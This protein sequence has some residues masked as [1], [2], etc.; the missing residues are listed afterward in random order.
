MD[1]LP[2]LT[3][4]TWLGDRRRSS[5]TVD[6]RPT[7]VVVWV[8]SDGQLKLVEAIEADSPVTV[9]LELMEKAA[10]NPLQGPAG[11][12]E[13]WLSP[14]VELK[15][16]PPEDLRVLEAAYESLEQALDATLP[17]Y[18]G[19]PEVTPERVAELCLAATDFWQRQLWTEIDD[20]QLARLE[21][22]D[23]S[24]IWASVMGGAELQRGLALFLN[25][26]AAV[27]A[28]NEDHAILARSSLLS[29]SFLNEQEAGPR[30]LAEAR[31]HNWPLP[32]PGLIP[33][34]VSTRRH[35]RSDPT[36]A[37][38]TLMLE[39]LEAVQATLP[40]SGSYKN[41][42]LRSGKKIR[43]RWPSEP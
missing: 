42:T 28:L 8:G 21:G 3:G 5:Q 41:H 33:W 11:Q 18:L 25:K 23:P 15:L 30:L 12:P 19:R 14:R 34:L 17:G 1:D 4:E 38:I 27:A 31:R 2:I 22:L 13:R 9:E 26:Q 7:D 20:V 32:E 40:L 36:E 6:G 37:E 16:P 39:A 24:P 43:V 29:L 35:D 10:R